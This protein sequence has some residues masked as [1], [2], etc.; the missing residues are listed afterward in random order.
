M[1]DL[2][3][4]LL[5]G[6]DDGAND[7]A[8][9]VR[10]CEIA[11]RDGCRAMVATPHLR[12]ERYEN[13]DRRLL[14]QA[15]RGLCEEVHRRFGDELKVFLGGEIAVHSQSLAEIDAL[16]ASSL[17]PLAGSRY[18]LLELSTHDL[19]PD[20]VE[21][22]YELGLAGWRPIIAHPERISWLVSDSGLLAAIVDHGG[23][24]QLTAMSLTGA[25]GPAIQNA[26]DHMMDQ[27]W[28][29]FV[30]SDAHD[31]RIRP[32]GLS[33]ARR[34][35]TKEWGRSVA[36]AIFERHPRAVLEDRPLEPTPLPEARPASP[37][38]SKT[39][40]WVARLKRLTSR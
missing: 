11:H 32:P 28:V 1:I 4:H 19:G 7:L 15:H 17:L 10:M 3:C 16:P 21:M 35:V 5:P 6:V 31:E 26:A 2:H 20:P 37:A 23:L 30:C 25:F 27:G 13:A 14:E 34:R 33:A 18:L 38:G 9:A 12:H 40:G 29:R 39:Q 22:V 8:Q 36:Q 24:L